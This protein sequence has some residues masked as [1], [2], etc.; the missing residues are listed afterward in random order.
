MKKQKLKVGDEVVVYPLEEDYFTEFTGTIL[1][2]NKGG[3]YQIKDKDGDTW[4]AVEEQISVL[5]S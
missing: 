1:S 3:Y 4:D 2:F 5:N